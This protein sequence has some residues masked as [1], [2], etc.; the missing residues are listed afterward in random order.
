M[1]LLLYAQQ[2]AHAI[3][4]K[5]HVWNHGPPKAALEPRKMPVIA[6]LRILRS[7]GLK[8]AFAG[9]P[10]SLLNAKNEATDFA[11]M[12]ARM[13][14]TAVALYFRMITTML[15]M[16]THI[17]ASSSARRLNPPQVQYETRC[18]GFKPTGKPPHDT[19]T[20]SSTS[21]TKKIIGHRKAGNQI[22]TP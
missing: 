9:C 19:A 14:M 4:T 13:R 2:R 3:G 12:D 21:S 22:R 1:H 11:P 16:E 7:D 17:G 6:P 5:Q 8:A 18:A 20:D 15:M 10:M